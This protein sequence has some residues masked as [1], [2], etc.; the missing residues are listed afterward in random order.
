MTKHRIAPSTAGGMTRRTALTAGA[1]ALCLP[2]VWRPAQAQSAAT[3][4]IMTWGGA[5]RFG[6]RIA[7][8]ERLHPKSAE[9]IKVQVVSPGA[10]DAE[11]YQA[12]RLGLASRTDVPDLVQMN[13]IGVPEFAEAGALADLSKLVEPYRADMTEAGREL[14]TYNGKVVGIPLQLKP[15]IWLYRTDLF[16]QAGIDPAGIKTFDE[17]VAA[18]RR[19]HE[20]HPKSF[21]MNIGSNPIH[22]WYFMLLSHWPDVRVADRSGKFQLASDKRFGEVLTWLKTFRTSGISLP[23]DDWSPD[24]Q[25]AFADGS[26]GGSLLS[27]WMTQFLPKFAPAQSGR[28]AIAPWPEFNRWG[29]EAGGAVFVIPSAAKNKEAAFEFA[30]KMLLDTSGSVDEWV[31]T[32]APPAVKSAVAEVNERARSMQRRDGMTDAE[33]AALPVNYFGKDFMKPVVESLNTFRVFPYDPAA[34]AELDIMRR[35][36]EGFLAGRTSLDQALAGMDAD[37]KRQI[38]NPYQ[39]S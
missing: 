19:F 7:A 11:V 30:S 31:R 18:G 20:K 17:Y 26:I 9:R 27:S 28:W 1:A 16:E 14:S 3:I 34:Q 29:S 22:Y 36:T 21:I 6:P 4:K 13:Y 10:H 23:V 25:P 35:Q 33:W 38:G 37:M 8:F 24:W 12:L 5:D 2:A 39:A 32:G 15:K